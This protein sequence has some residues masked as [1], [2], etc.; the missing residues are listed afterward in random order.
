MMVPDHLR[1]L[2]AITDAQA[3]QIVEWL[4]PDDALMSS[5][6]YRFNLPDGWNV[7]LDPDGDIDTDGRFVD[8]SKIN[9][10]FYSRQIDPGPWEK[11]ISEAVETLRRAQLPPWRW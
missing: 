4:N 3:E 10:W 6:G 1:Q 5:N 2:T 11:D 9:V 8:S 7:I